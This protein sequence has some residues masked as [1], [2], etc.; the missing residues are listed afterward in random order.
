MISTTGSLAETIEVFDVYTG[1]QIGQ[2]RK[3]IAVAIVYRA[4]DR[5]LSSEEIDQLQ[6]KIVS[7]LK[8]NFKA[9]IRDR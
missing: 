6:Q 3:S 7:G 9:E 8:Q 2:G 1:A 4:Q 5:S